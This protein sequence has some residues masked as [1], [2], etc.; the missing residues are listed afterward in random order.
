M[1]R[2]R[3]MTQY[4]VISDTSVESFNSRMAWYLDE[5]WEVHGPLYVSTPSTVPM[6][7]LIQVMVSYDEEE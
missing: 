6:R 3:K 4:H 7:E 1:G 5:G 2:A